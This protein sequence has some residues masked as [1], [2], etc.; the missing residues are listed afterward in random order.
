MYSGKGFYLGPVER[1]GYGS[2]L[3]FEQVKLEK[4]TGV[5]TLYLLGTKSLSSRSGEE[6]KV[7]NREQNLCFGIAY[8]LLWKDLRTLYERAGLVEAELFLHVLHITVR[9]RK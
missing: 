7:I 2:H 3:G 9:E 1:L 6:P 5:I 4:D 8:C